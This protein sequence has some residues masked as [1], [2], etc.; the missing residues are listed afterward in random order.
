MWPGAVRG[1]KNIK[2][3]AINGE[4]TTQIYDPEGVEVIE[5]KYRLRVL[6]KVLINIEI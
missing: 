6:E 5:E 4:M 2:A 3:L 1:F